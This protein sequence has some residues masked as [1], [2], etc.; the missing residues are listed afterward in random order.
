MVV[1][2]KMTSNCICGFWAG[3]GV[4]RSRYTLNFTLGL[5]CLRGLLDRG[6]NLY[7]SMRS[8]RTNRFCIKMIL[9]IFWC[10]SSSN[11]FF[12]LPQ[13]GNMDEATTI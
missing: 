9:L 13:F 8:D 10:S 4:S 12:I 11:F 7:T 3:V 5:H 2:P 1:E 6:G